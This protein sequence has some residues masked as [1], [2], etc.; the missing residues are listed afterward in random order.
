M[1]IIIGDQQYGVVLHIAY[2][3]HQ[4]SPWTVEDFLPVFAIQ[5]DLGRCLAH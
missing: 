2:K 1:K 5:F 4:L 3:S